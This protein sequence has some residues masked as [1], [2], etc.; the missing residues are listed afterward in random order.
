MTQA[1]GGDGPAAVGL[2][3][4]HRNL[5]VYYVLESLLLGPLF[6]ALLVPRLLKYRTLRYRLDEA[7]LS[8]EWGALFRREVSLSYARIQDIHLATN[9]VERW[10]GLGRVQVQTASGSS[11]AEMTIEGL[12]DYE[13]VRDW[14][15]GRMRGAR[16]RGSAAAEAHGV[17]AGAA[18]GGATAAAGAAPAV[19]P[20]A[21]TAALRET[22]EELRQVRLLL[23]A[24]LAGRQGRDGG[25]GS[26]T[27]GGPGGGS[28]A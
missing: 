17:A 19:A 5:L 20:D 8:A 18:G 12:R 22:T 3:R 11:R 15:Y 26:G 23:E 27:G 6:P 24:A 14:I 10:L 21:V 25:G 1:E 28:G 2:R 9:L 7:G 16:R 13:A 4:P